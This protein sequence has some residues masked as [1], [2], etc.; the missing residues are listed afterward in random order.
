MPADPPRAKNDRSWKPP[1]AS[2]VDLNAVYEAAL[3][4]YFADRHARV[5]AFVG[6]H[7]SLRGALRTHRRA[8][9][10]DILRAPVNLLL[11][12]PTA[13][14]KFS[15]VL[16]RRA[17]ASGT[18]HW[19]DTRNLLLKTAVSRHITDLIEGS[20]SASIRRGAA[21]RAKQIH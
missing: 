3:T 21:I 8:V 15:A 6:R 14:L 5:D 10:L 4:R 13:A 11:T 20:F 9:G 17:G 12:V 18:A 19:L 7:F 1:P 16:A 2:A